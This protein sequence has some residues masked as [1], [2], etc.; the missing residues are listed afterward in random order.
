MCVLS[1]CLIF[2]FVFADVISGRLASVLLIPNGKFVR[3]P[4]NGKPWVASGHE[5]PRT[6]FEFTPLNDF[7]KDFRANG[8]KW[9]LA[10]CQKD[11]DQDGLTNGEELGDPYCIWSINSNSTPT[12][13]VKSHPGICEPL[14]SPECRRYNAR[15]YEFKPEHCSS[16]VYVSFRSPIDSFLCTK[17]QRLD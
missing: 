17:D 10:I 15:F 9:D 2:V 8:F 14:Y 4:C 3:N 16:V 1:V 6:S 13:D 7:G 5:N 12:H 11:S